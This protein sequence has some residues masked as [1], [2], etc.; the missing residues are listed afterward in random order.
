MYTTTEKLTLLDGYQQSD[1][2]LN[3]YAD[4]HGVG[5]STLTKWIKQFLSAGLAGVRRPERN[6]RYSLEEKLAAVRDFQSGQHTAQ[7][8]IERRHIRNV[9]QLHHWVIQYNRNELT[10]EKSARKRAKKMGRKVGFEEKKAIVQWVLEHDKNYHAAAKKYDITYY[11][12]YS[13]VQKYLEAGEDWSAL[14]DRRGKR[15]TNDSELSEFDRVKQENREL[16]KKL[17]RMEVQIAF[18]KKLT[19]IRNRGVKDPTDVRRFK[20]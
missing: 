19:E 13:W 4:Y 12:V 14:E 5:A 18:A 1:Y 3:V 15:K 20:K 8:I 10:A 7:E 6:R 9:S 2:S 17:R 11:R 16:K